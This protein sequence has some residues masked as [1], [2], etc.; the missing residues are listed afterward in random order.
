MLETIF[1]T[2]A[3]AC[4]ALIFLSWGLFAIDQTRDFSEQ[5]VE[6]IAGREVAREASPPP[7][8]ERVRERAHVWPREVVDDANDVLLAPFASLTDRKDPPWLRRSVPA[9]LG[10]LAFGVGFGFLARFTRGTP[11]P[12]PP[13][14]DPYRSGP[15]PARPRDDYTDDRR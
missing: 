13:L 6:E 2:A 5:T 3:I 1:R 10:L 12:P 14:V 7:Y 8:R 15:P 4:S 11:G 9:I